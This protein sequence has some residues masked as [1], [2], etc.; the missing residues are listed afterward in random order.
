MK[1][2]TQKKKRK[3]LVKTKLTKKQKDLILKNYNLD[4]AQSLSTIR[5]TMEER[6]KRKYDNTNV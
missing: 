5:D 1:T 2:K 4:K 6:I 3:A